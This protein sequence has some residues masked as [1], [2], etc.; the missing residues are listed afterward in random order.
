MMKIYLMLPA[1][2]TNDNLDYWWLCKWSTIWWPHPSWKK[3]VCFLIGLAS[4]SVCHSLAAL[5]CI[6]K[7]RKI[8]Q[9]L[10]QWVA[11]FIIAMQVNILAAI[12]ILSQMYFLLNGSC[13]DVYTVAI[14]ELSKAGLVTSILSTMGENGVQIPSPWKGKA[15][16]YIQEMCNVIKTYCIWI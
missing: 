10:H 14:K 9:N 4:F 7:V 2:K 15:P 12:R 5:F 8:N 11:R 3:G 16:Y 13:G 1:F 6:Q